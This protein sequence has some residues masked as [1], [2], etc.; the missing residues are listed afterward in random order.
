MKK[1]LQLVVQLV[2][3]AIV[4]SGCV[5]GQS[6]DMNY[7]ATAD[8]NVGGGKAVMANVTDAR[9]FVTSGDKAPHFIGQYR[10]GIGI[11]YDVST[12]GDVPLA[13][14][15]ERDIAKDLSSLGFAAGNSGRKLNITIDDW[16][17]D[18]YQNGRFTYTFALSVLNAK[19]ST[20]ATSKV[21]DEVTVKGNFW[22]GGKG[23]FEKAM[24]QMYRDAII[25]LVRDNDKVLSALS[26]K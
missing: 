11:P 19:G 25:A 3:A 9:P 13:D 17:F 26:G 18:T 14:L 1:Q 20:L 16:N 5:V 12:D 7:Q 15:I 6:L 22:T 4:L 21:S 8:S 24:P 23:S 2:I 10:A